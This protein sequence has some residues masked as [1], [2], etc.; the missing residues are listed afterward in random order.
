MVRLNNDDPVIVTIDSGFSLDERMAI[1]RAAAVWNAFGNSSLGHDL[2][3][4]RTDSIPGGSEPGAQTD[5]NFNGSDSS[6]RVMREVSA[7]RWTALSLTSDNPGVTIRCHSGDSLVKQVVILNPTYTNPQ[8]F[9]S[10]ALHELGHAIGLDHSCTFTDPKA[11]FATCSG[12]AQDHPYHLAVM[13]P[14]L[15]TSRTP[16]VA[17]EMKEDLRANDMERAMC[18]YR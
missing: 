13:F 18:L 6:L 12:I 16:G 1:E 5:C 7:T 8:Q 15:R 9:M 11:D 4:L 17:P 2:F 14:V 3:R 10:V